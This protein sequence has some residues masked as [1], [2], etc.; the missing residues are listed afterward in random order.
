MQTSI[1]PEKFKRKPSKKMV[2]EDWLQ[3]GIERG[4]K[5]NKPQRFDHKRRWGEG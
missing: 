3:E 5:Y 1:K 4:K 2:S